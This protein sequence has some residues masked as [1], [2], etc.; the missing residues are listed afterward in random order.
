[1]DTLVAQILSQI[2]FTDRIASEKGQYRRILKKSGLISFAK[3][4]RMQLVAMKYNA[5]NI[6]GRKSL[7]HMHFARGAKMK[8]HVRVLGKLYMVYL[9]NEY[10]PR[11]DDL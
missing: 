5:I 1:M 10:R 8:V 11:S 3:Q 2:E 4:I 6:V 7:K 9:R